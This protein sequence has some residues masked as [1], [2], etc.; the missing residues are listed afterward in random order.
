MTWDHITTK[1]REQAEKRIGAARVQRIAERVAC[2]EKET[3]LR[4]FAAML[5]GK[6]N[7]TVGVRNGIASSHCSSQ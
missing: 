1:L 2:M 4:A 7:V 5:A 3:D 6:D